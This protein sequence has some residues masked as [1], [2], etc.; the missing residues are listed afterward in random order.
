MGTVE[1]SEMEK[2]SHKLNIKTLHDLGLKMPRITQ[3]YWLAVRKLSIIQMTSTY[4]M[5][6]AEAQ[7]PGTI[8]RWMKEY[9][10]KWDGE[11]WNDVRF[12]A[13]PLKVN[14]SFKEL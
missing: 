10:Y 4:F 11:K 13:D 9:G 7:K 6:I 2:L 8:Y 1:M 3:K 12:L 14:E 5:H